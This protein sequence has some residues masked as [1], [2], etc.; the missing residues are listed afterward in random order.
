MSNSL[1]PANDQVWR[2]DILV[3]GEILAATLSPES[4]Y[5]GQWSCSQTEDGM[6]AQA[7]IIAFNQERRCHYW[8]R[9][10][11]RI[12][13]LCH[14]A[15]LLPSASLS[16]GRIFRRPTS[17]VFWSS[18]GTSSHRLT[19][20]SITSSVAARLVRWS[21]QNSDASLLSY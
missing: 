8:N 14:L 12:Q 6:V 3:S 5:S 13:S 17:A 19:S 7:S 2:R 20:P 16:V 11:L 21:Q 4:T 1:N 18:N 15:A 10:I 9:C